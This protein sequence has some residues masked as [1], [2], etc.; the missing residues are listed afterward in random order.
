VNVGH[1]SDFPIEGGRAI[2]YGP[3]QIAVFRFESRNEWYATENTCPHKREAVLARG[4]IGDKAG[5][6]KVACPLHKKT[7]SLQTGKCLS[8]ENLQVQVFPVRLD[9]DKVLV[10][11]PPPDDFTFS[12]SSAN[13]CSSA[14]ACV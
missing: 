11:L 1:V 14:V 13:V 2:K 7:F 9:G 12:T 4:I 8:G 10:E 6:P 3:T 5:E